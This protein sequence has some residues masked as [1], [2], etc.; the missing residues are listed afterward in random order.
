MLPES[1]PDDVYRL[2]IDSVEDY[3]MFLIDL[4]GRVA[5]WN[6]GAERVKLWRAEEIIGEHYGVLSTREDRDAGRPEERLRI[7]AR[8]GTYSEEGWRTRKG[9]IRYWAHITL[10]ALRDDDDA[11]V[12]FAKITRDLSARQRA[13]AERARLHSELRVHEQRM[14]LLVDGINDY[15][16]VSLDGD[17]RVQSWNAGARAL[18]GWS[19]Q[20]VIGRHMAAL[21][22][23]GATTAADGV[24]EGWWARRDGSRARVSWSVSDVQ[25][26]DGQMVGQLVVVRD[27]TED[28][29][30]REELVRLAS[31]DPLTGLA[32]RRRFDEELE[33]VRRQARRRGE[34]FAVLMIDLDD[35][36]RSTT[37]TATASVT[38]CSSPLRRSCG[39]D[40]ARSICSHAWA[41]TSSG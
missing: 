35:F 36:R 3:A 15:A 40:C 19:A 11:L 2:F 14:R 23:D 5:S 37:C 33:R 4:D 13:E 21:E 9:G 34:P 41:A 24:Q 18:T 39:G 31:Q 20:E 6:A 12:G 29:L 1:I 17:G 27:L 30:I 26:P 28:G 32:N 7:A 10:T 38:S 16:I 8:D 25:A 22:P